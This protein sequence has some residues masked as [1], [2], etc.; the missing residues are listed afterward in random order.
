MDEEPALGEEEE[1]L[2]PKPMQQLTPSRSRRRLN[3]AHRRFI[4][5]IFQLCE[6]VEEP[7]TRTPLGYVQIILRVPANAPYQADTSS[8]CAPRSA[9]KG[10]LVGLLDGGIATTRY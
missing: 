4:K 7:V 8:F 6:L 9:E 5:D 1:A 10:W 3:K 2:Q